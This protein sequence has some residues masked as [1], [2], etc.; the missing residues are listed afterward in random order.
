MS[1]TAERS[2]ALHRSGVG[3]STRPALPAGPARWSTWL[4]LVI[5][6]ACFLLINLATSSRSPTIWGDEVQL[7]D[8]AVNVLMGRG[9]VSSAWAT[10]TKDEMFAGNSPLYSV[11]LVPW[12]WMFGL[13]PTAVRSLNYVLMIAAA[14]VLA[15]ACHRLGIVR[16][17]RGLLLLVL[18]LYTGHA[19]SFSFRSGR[20]DILGVLLCALLLAAYTIPRPAPRHL[21]LVCLAAFLPW[22]GLQLIPFFG[23]VAGVLLLLPRA[24]FRPALLAVGAGALI[25]AAAMAWGLNALGVWHGFTASVVAEDAVVGGFSERLNSVV[26]GLTT[27]PSSMLLLSSLMVVLFLQGRRRFSE[28]PRALVAGLLLAFTIPAVLGL[29]GHFPIYYGWMKFV[30]LSICAVSAYEVLRHSEPRLALVCLAGIVA[31]TFSL[32]ARLFLTW[33]EWD[34]RNYAPVEAFVAAHVTPSDIVYCVGP[35]YYPA[36]RLAKEVFLPPYLSIINDQE[37]RQISVLVVDP[38]LP[39]RKSVV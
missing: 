27:C 20:Y 14:M 38:R 1:L 2:T 16:S 24:N 9:F 32:P 21:T 15:L 26:A 17:R 29:C 4:L 3:S 13:H 39:D 25:G 12:L 35:A 34:V 36:K 5:V 23:A 19:L 22:A 11:L 6:S 8:P 18:L 33:R 37:Q 28:R 31:A 10:Q 7:A 30:P